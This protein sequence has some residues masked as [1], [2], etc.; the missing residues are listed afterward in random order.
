MRLRTLTLALAASAGI[1]A[2]GWQAGAA[3]EVAVARAGSGGTVPASGDGAGSSAAPSGSYQGQ[4]VQ[5]RY[6]PVQ[7]Q[8]TVSDGKIT[9]VAALQLP[10]NDGHSARI[11]SAVEPMLRSE[12]LSAQ[13]ADI[14]TISGATY[15]SEAY[16]SSL[17]SAL[18]NTR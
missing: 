12:V 2:A 8:V 10:Q 7:V 1:V 9:D 13:S 17:Q 14:Q 16:A 3:H 6:G 18:D 15:T 4:T 11:S 5:T